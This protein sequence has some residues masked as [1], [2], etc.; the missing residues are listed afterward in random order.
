[1]NAEYVCPKTLYLN[2]QIPQSLNVSQ[3]DS[4]VNPRKKLPNKLLGQQYKRDKAAVNRHE[5]KVMIK[6]KMHQ[7]N[8]QVSG[9]TRNS[10]QNLKSVDS[11]GKSRDRKDSK[12]RQSKSKIVTQRMENL[13]T[14]KTKRNTTHTQPDEMY[15]Q[16]GR[17]G[18][19]D[20]L[21]SG[22]RD[23]SSTIVLQNSAIRKHDGQDA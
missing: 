21:D 16:T 5:I 4:P 19:S 6:P 20:E 18:M 1:M 10:N 7:S 13:K 22:R 12:D 8:K 9:K 2:N 17:E 3:N 11:Q 15:R 23:P 14:E